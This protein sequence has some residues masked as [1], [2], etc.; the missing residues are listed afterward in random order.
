MI[1]EHLRESLA[2]HPHS[3]IRPFLWYGGESKELVKREI[4]AIREGGADEFILE[5]R[6]GDWF[7]TDFWWDLFGFVLETAKALNM[8][9]WCVDDS[10]VNTGSANDSLSKPENAKYRAKNLRAD[11]M[12]VAGPLVSGAVSLPRHTGN[13]KFVR[14]TAF[15]LD[16]ETGRTYGEGIDLT[17]N[18]T[19]GICLADLPGG[20]WRIYFVMTVDPEKNGVFRNYIT[21]VSKESC[22]HLIDEVHEKMY[23][24]FGEYFGNTFAGFFSD[25]P[26]FGNNDGKY[27]AE[28][29]RIRLGQLN[30]M[31]PWWDDFPERLAAKYG[32]SPEKVMTLLPALW[33]D[34][35]G[36][37]AAFRLAYM[38][39]ITELWQENFSGQIGRWCEAHGVEYIGHN[40]EDAGAHTRTGWGCGHY[41]RSMSGQHMSGMDIVF[42]QMIPGIIGIEHAMNDGPRKR[43]SAFYQC[44][45]P[46]LA[47]SLAHITPSMRN[48][49][50]CEIFG[51][52]GWTCGVSSMM[53]MFNTC[54]VNGVNHYVPHAYAMSIPKVFEQ[55]AARE[56]SEASYTPPG[57]V[58]TYL[59]PTFYTG[60]YNPQFPI[61]GQ[62]IR[63]VRRVSN[64]FSSGIHQA[65]V[66]VYYDAEADWMNAGEYQ[67]LEPVAVKLATSG[68]DYEFLPLDTLLTGCRAESGRL[69]VNEERYGALIVPMTEIITDRLLTRLGELASAGLPVIFTGKL[70]ERSE[71]G[72]VSGSKL[73][74]FRTAQLEDLPDYLS[75]IVKP[76]L[77][78]DRP[79]P[80]LRRYVWREADGGEAALLFNSGLETITFRLTGKGDFLVYDP[81]KNRLCRCRADR[82]LVLRRGQLLAVYFSADATGDLPEYAPAEPEMRVLPLR[83][84][85]RA[86]KA[87]EKEFTLLRKASPAVNL[88]VAE[89]LTRFCG[90]FRY[91]AEFDSAEGRESVL[92]IP[93][94][95]DAAEVLL[96]GET[97]G[98][99]FGPACRFEIA[100][101]VKA[102]RNKLEIRTFDNPAYADREEGCI[103]WGAG[104]PLRQHGFTGEILIG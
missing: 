54:L 92:E 61:F 33:D 64:L 72:K 37:S 38:D 3:C 81:W 17:G 97:C 29:Y 25:E 8:R 53:A 66:A 11:A 52:A 96:N 47:A 90:E 43:D 2:G 4:L 70:P 31:F 55:H 102:G 98:V 27:G 36:V 32:A 57:Y 18:V 21:M 99:E 6:G 74:H 45:L 39:M 94:A 59:P 73:R 9:V 100:G 46:K 85:I 63:H 80:A 16:P 30:R 51:A 23:A 42:E 75:R 86:R 93:G 103:G 50:L 44:V 49:A 28:A 79:V 82:P 56:E 41:F 67:P 10:H 101:K 22:R 40:L 7:A 77:V 88:N 78:T 24:H 65:D 1:A 76:G 71:S 15:A 14:I 5:N 12:D 104:M 34:M 87:G 48:R 26:A 58:M 13:E 62:I 35:D 19:D 83:Y 20:L 84:D 89:K 60:G 95:G 68:Y 91:E 69:A